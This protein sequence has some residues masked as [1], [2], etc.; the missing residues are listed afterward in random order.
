MQTV[1][2]LFA[3]LLVLMALS[4][5][6]TAHAQLI[7]PFNQTAIFEV[8]ASVQI[9]SPCNGGETPTFDDGG[10]DLIGGGCTPYCI[11]QRIE[12]IVQ[13]RDKVKS[14]TA[15]FTIT[16]NDGTLGPVTVPVEVVSPGRAKQ[17]GGETQW[18]GGGLTVT[19]TG[20]VTKPNNGGQ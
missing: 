3:P 7:L 4:F 5:A 1:R 9:D 20:F 11:P 2:R 10:S 18:T 13:S 6:T 17:R 15:S 14:G 16:A 19:L 12:G 8:T